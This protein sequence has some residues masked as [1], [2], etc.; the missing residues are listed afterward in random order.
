VSYGRVGQNLIVLLLVISCG[1]SAENQAA[2]NLEDPR[3]QAELRATYRREL[4]LC[5]AFGEQQTP[6]CLLALAVEK[7]NK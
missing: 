2:A 3:R 5:E 4:R 1:R 6:T 7:R